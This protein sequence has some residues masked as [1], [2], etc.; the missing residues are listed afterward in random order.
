MWKPP[1]T[2]LEAHNFC[3]DVFNRRPESGNTS[4][5]SVH[6]NMFFLQIKSLYIF[7]QGNP[8]NIADIVML[9]I[10]KNKSSL[11]HILKTSSINTN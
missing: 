11:L 6:F 2:L 8:Q 9:F 5:A 4:P 7:R 3:Q 1:Y 10:L